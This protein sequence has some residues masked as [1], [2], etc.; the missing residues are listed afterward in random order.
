MIT[1]R[2]SK[3]LEASLNNAVKAS[4]T[5][6]SDFIRAVL[7]DALRGQTGNRAWELGK[8]VFGKYSSNSN[9]RLA[10]DSEL[11]LSARLKAN[12]DHEA[13]RH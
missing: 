3:E 13:N 2:L 5:T 11:I 4:G 12:A 9:G 10:E 8:S 6:K 7:K 1:L